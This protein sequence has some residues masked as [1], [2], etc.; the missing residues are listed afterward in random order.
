MSALTSQKGRPR[1]WIRKVLRVLLVF[2]VLA[3]LGGGVLYGWLYKNILST[4]PTDLSGLRDFRPITSVIVYA[5]D[6]S[7]VDEFYLERRI[8]VPLDELPEHVW[9]AFLQAEDRRFFKHEG[10]DLLGIARA[11]VVNLRAG[12]VQQ[13]GS[14]LTQQLV[15]NLLVGNEVSYR[16]KIREAVLS[17]RL[18]NE[19]SKQEILELYLNFVPLGSGNYGVEA[20]SRDYFGVSARNLDVGQ[21]ALLAGLV[22][23]PSR[24]SPRSN[25]R[26]ARDR[27][28]LVLERMV[29]SGLVS[30]EVAELARKAPVLID[31]EG[32][33]EDRPALSYVTEVRRQIRALF[34]D[35]V[36]FALGLRVQTALDLEL[37]R[38]AT[39]AVREAVDAHLAR[40]G[41]L[42]PRRNLSPAEQ[43][44]FLQQAPGFSHDPETGDLLP[45]A[46]GQCFE[47]LASEGDLARLTAG[48]WS[49]SIDPAGRRT[50]VLV[51]DP[52]EDPEP[53]DEVVAAGDVLSVCLKEESQVVL[54]RRPWAE[55]AA[56]VIEN[57]T[58]RV[59]ALVG[60]YNESLEG[61]VRATQARR[62][63]GSSFKPYLYAA[64]LQRGYTQLDRVL[65]APLALPA[66]GGRW[67]RPG[68]Y[69]GTYEG[70]VT[71]RKALA[72]S[73][74]TV[75]V[76]L[77][78]ETGASEV[79]R[80]AADMGVRTPL[81]ADL[82]MALGASE[83]T[84]MD[85][86]IG[87][88]TIARDGVTM[89]PVYIN[90]LHDAEDRLLARAGQSVSVEGY[91]VRTLP[92][93]P[94]QRA[95]P[96]GV[97]YELKDML[98]EVVREGTARRARRTDLDRA[99]K[100]GTTNGFQ[101]AWFC[102]FTP[103]YTVIVWVGTDG[104]RTLGDKETG[105]RTAL[106]AWI[107]IVDALGEPPG[108]LFTPPPEVALVPLDGDWVAVPRGSIPERVL[109]VP[110]L[111]R[112]PLPS[113]GGRAR[114]RGAQ[115]PSVL[116]F[117]APE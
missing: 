26:I 55:G 16:R 8:W 92:G 45:P 36:P 9:Q 32:M 27:R 74:N 114:A 115:S 60:G 12:E 99:G 42:G 73:L 91:G 75:A 18:E 82:A 117:S 83:V 6:G 69:D 52:E 3:L 25:A 65:D 107:T 44:A 88:S 46:P 48:P 93:G 108:T 10:V 54:D 89:E 7:Q 28:E 110:E 112:A 14:T 100:T 79:A 5:A 62:Q 106:P 109:R 40:V 116:T 58:G 34:G 11:V 35:E 76:R 68:N 97:A 95:L 81:R 37:Q 102:G 113:F 94:G 49:F 4:L 87:F 22:P 29:R 31:R 39:E 63:P 53:L 86:A 103:N 20:A 21:A 23:A 85:Q 98:R 50:P 71:L 56:V 47:A 80:L 19:L 72:K 57:A 51:A 1:Q 30:P 13:G 15:K 77:I 61:F 90:A 64:A 84:P 101:D 67:W 33:E 24:Y 66:G 41:P 2:T 17:W 111:G 104:T 96:A 70:M 59:L 38:V 78:V 105:A 43:A